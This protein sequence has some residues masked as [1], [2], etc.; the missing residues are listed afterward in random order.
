MKGFVINR[1][2]GDVKLLEPGLR[3][4]E[5]KTGK[6]VLGVLPYLH[7]LHLEA[8]DAVISHQHIEDQ[9]TVLNVTVP[10]LTRTSNHTDFDPLRLH[11]EVNVHF[12][13][14]GQPIPE[15][16]L[17][18]IPGTKNT[19]TDLEF[20]KENGWD[21]DILRHL[22]YG[23][24][25]MGICGGYQMLGKAIHD[26]D[27]IEGAAGSSDALN[28][29]DL[30]T[31]MI[32]QKTLTRVSGTLQ[33]PGQEPVSVTGYEIHAGVTTGSGLEKPLIQLDQEVDGVMSDDGQI[34]GTYLHGVFE[35]PDACTAILKWAGLQEASRIDYH[36]LRE[37]GINRMADAIEE[38]LDMRQIFELCGV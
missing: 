15:C 3:W 1:F 38:S 10:I 20:V 19:R 9:K 18:I 35:Q 37:D 36:L 29:L 2:R 23:G 16:D 31:T 27:G 7:G 4:L 14:K 13:G 34:F 11:P 24:K 28:L 8:E 21:Q 17:V 12:V 30:E 32:R 5:E 25:L 33:L 22:R 6:P 26:P